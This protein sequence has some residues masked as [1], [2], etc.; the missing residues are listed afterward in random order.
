LTAAV[1]ANGG[2][3]ADERVELLQLARAGHGEQARHGPFES[4]TGRHVPKAQSN[5]CGD[6]RHPFHIDVARLKVRGSPSDAAVTLESHSAPNQ[7]GLL[8]HDH[9]SPHSRSASM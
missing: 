4:P 9:A 3:Q 2:G 1:A 8:G 6:Q 5:T 7:H